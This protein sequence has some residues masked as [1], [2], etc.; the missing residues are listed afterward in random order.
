MNWGNKLILVFIAF[1]GFMGFLV[2]KC[3]QTPV[4]LVSADYYKDELNYQQVIDGKERAGTLTSQVAV[5]VQHDHV[6]VQ[7]PQEMKQWQ[8]TGHVWFY[9]ITNGKNDRRLPLATDETGSQQFELKQFSP[10]RYRVKTDWQAAG[11][12]YYSEN[13]IVIP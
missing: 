7:L 4:S 6:S 1:A 9:C 11:E 8:P 13:E 5:T 12:S 10:G 2:Y 3:M